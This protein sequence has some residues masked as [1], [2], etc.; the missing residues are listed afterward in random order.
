MSVL[1][2]RAGLGA[3]SL[4]VIGYPLS[5]WYRGA[6]FTWDSML[7]VTLFP[8]FG[9]LAFTIMYLHII[10]RPFASILERY[11]S[12]SRFER[13]S[14]HVVLLSIILHPL[15]RGIYMLIEGYPLWIGV[16]TEL[17]ITLG[18]L[19]FL[20]LISYDLGK[21]LARSAFVARYWPAIDLMST[22]G[23]YVIWL[24][25]F[26]IGSDL[27]AGPMRMVWI[28]YGATALTASL[29]VFVCLQ[30]RRR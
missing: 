10:G 18:V 25:A 23:F 6:S 16:G 9:L 20:L 11:V 5:M 2:A 4:I 1:L 7:L 14:S 13:I 29:Y 26:L 12:F 3:F 24:H 28:F 30:L 22:V 21:A 8:A 19:G 27:H 17:S 15:L